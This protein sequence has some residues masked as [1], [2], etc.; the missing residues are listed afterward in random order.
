M[1]DSRKWVIWVVYLAS[2]CALL[3]C[4]NK[5][6]EREAAAEIDKSG[7]AAENPEMQPSQLQEEQEAEPDP[8]EV[9]VAE[10]FEGEVEA[11][12][13]EDNYL[14]ELERLEKEIESE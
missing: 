6:S 13:T 14:A 2:L 10:D 5:R 7:V 4:C 11:S 9:P 12:V 3:I 8:E 1:I